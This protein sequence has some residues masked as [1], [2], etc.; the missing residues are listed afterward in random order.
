MLLPPYKTL[1][2]NYAFVLDKIRQKQGRFPLPRLSPPLRALLCVPGSMPPEGVQV[3][4]VDEKGAIKPRLTIDPTAPYPIGEHGLKWPPGEDPSLNG[5]TDQHLL[6]S[7]DFFQL[8]FLA[9]QGA[10]LTASSLPVSQ[11]AR[12][13]AA[14][15]EQA[16]RMSLQFSSQLQW[17]LP[18]GMQSNS[19]LVFGFTAEPFTMNR[20]SFHQCWRTVQLLRT[21]QAAWEQAWQGARAML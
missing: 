3:D 1:F 16:M 4:Q 7:F 12:D 2:A 13:A 15:Y 18:D 19:R 9:R 6:P 14:Y 5:N 20:W 10:I 8:R 11:S 17:L 21:E